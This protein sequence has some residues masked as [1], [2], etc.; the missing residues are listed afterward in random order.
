MFSEFLLYPFLG[1]RHSRKVHELKINELL[2]AIEAVVASVG[3]EY[4]IDEVKIGVW[5]IGNHSRVPSIV[6]LLSKS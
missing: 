2:H 3:N 6:P 1:K 4:S 5:H